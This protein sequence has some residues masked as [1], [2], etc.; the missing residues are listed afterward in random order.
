MLGQK[1]ITAAAGNAGGGEPLYAED[2]FSTHLYTGDLSDRS[3]VNGVDLGGEGG[4]VWLKAR[5]QAYSHFLFDTER[6][7]SATIGTEDASGQYNSTRVTSFNSDGFDL[8][9]DSFANGTGI[10]YASWTF[11]KAPGFFDVVTYTGDGVAGRTV[12]HNLG[13]T[14]GMIWVKSTSSTQIWLCYH[15]SVGETQYLQVNGLSNAVT[16]TGA[17]NNT[18]P[19]STSLLLA[20]AQRL[21]RAESLI[22]PMSSPTTT[23]DLER[24]VTKLSS[25]AA[26]TRGTSAAGNQVSLGRA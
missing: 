10:E 1:I 3:I 23:S 2:V 21:T 26:L 7:V 4:M 13:S 11:R 5:D 6:G 19:T 12:A 15:R 14:P 8:T 20:L 16:A 25:S 22:S 18:E 24:T 17:W 9:T